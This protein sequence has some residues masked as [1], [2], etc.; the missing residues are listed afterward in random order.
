[1]SKA[2][3]DWVSLYEEIIKEVKT[4]KINKHIYLLTGTFA[5]GIFIGL[6]LFKNV[7]L[8]LVIGAVGFPLDYLIYQNELYYLLNLHKPYLLEGIIQK[9]IQKIL[10]DE[11]TAEK[12]EVF[13]FEIEV[14]EAIGFDRDGLDA[15]DLVEK[16]GTFRLEVPKSM[17]LS[18]VS[19]EEISVVCTPE[20]LV[21]GWVREE[22]VIRIE[23]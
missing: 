4:S 14:Q 18:L 7:N 17:F 20:D 5:I 16:K 19:G 2:H 13:Y 8:A 21:W 12:T 23:N 22:E 15:M 3:I 11:T 10:I 9:R 1:M 6:F